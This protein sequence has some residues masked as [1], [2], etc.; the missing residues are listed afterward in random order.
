MYNAFNLMF[1]AFCLRMWNILHAGTKWSL[2]GF[3]ITSNIIQNRV[4]PHTYTTA[5]ANNS[6]YLSQ[7]IEL[8]DH[9]FCHINIYDFCTEL[10]DML[11]ILKR[12]RLL[13]FHSV[14]WYSSL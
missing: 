2:A 6:W 5:V 1:N 7:F 9:C 3:C 11:I 14:I 10:T 4:Q 12:S 13:L 8:S